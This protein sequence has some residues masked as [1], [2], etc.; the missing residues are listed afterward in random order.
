[1]TCQAC[2]AS[3]SLDHPGGAVS[4]PEDRRILSVITERDLPKFVNDPNEGPPT[5]NETLARWPY[6]A[7]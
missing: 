4:R 2:G 6:K 5:S 7:A 1:M 3:L